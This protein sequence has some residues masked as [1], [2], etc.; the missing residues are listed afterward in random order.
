[1]QQPCDDGDSGLAA[2]WHHQDSEITGVAVSVW[3]GEAEILLH[4]RMKVGRT[5]FL[6]H[7]IMRL[8]QFLHRSSNLT[9]VFAMQRFTCLLRSIHGLYVIESVTAL[10][11]TATVIGLLQ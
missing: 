10:Y 5:G 11:C 1:V 9:L 4:V 3:D 6:N 8:K 2:V 7:E